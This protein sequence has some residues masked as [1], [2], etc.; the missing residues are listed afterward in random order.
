LNPFTI[1]PSDVSQQSS[2]VRDHSNALTTNRASGPSRSVAAQAH[3]RSSQFATCYL[4]TLLQL[5]A[6][7]LQVQRFWQKYQTIS[8]CSFPSRKWF[9]EVAGQHG[10][11]D[12]QILLNQQCKKNLRRVFKTG[13][14]RN[15]QFPFYFLKQKKKPASSCPGTKSVR[16]VT[17][18]RRIR[19]CQSWHIANSRRNMLAASSLSVSGFHGKNASLTFSMWASS[20]SFPIEPTLD[21]GTR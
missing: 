17:I 5:N 6:T 4:F 18:G 1:S 3:R 13:M 16:H 21:R 12:A 19:F 15:W 8:V 14:T 11:P 20:A 2:L 7:S 9:F 10:V